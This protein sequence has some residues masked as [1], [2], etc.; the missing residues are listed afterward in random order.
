MLKNIRMT[1]QFKDKDIV[2]K[3]ITSMTRPKLEYIAVVYL[4]HLKKDVRK[5]EHFQRTATRML[6]ELKDLHTV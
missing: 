3:I 5:L 4:P 1:F 6:L 2:S